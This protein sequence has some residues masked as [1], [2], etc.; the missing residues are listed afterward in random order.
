M[1]VANNTLT[2]NFPT[3]NDKITNNVTTYSHNHSLQK[4]LGKS[5]IVYGYNGYNPED[6]TIILIKRELNLHKNYT[7]L[8]KKEIAHLKA[9]NIQLEVSLNENNSKSSTLSIRDVDSFSKCVIVLKVS[10]NFFL[11]IF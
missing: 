11:K 8:L 7:D 6:N 9:V 2:S 3:R 5:N 4:D 1:T 10:K